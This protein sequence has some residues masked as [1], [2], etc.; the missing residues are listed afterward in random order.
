MMQTKLDDMK[1]VIRQFREIS[2]ELLAENQSLSEQLKIS[3][4]ACQNIRTELEKCQKDHKIEIDDLK[5]RISELKEE[6]EFLHSDKDESSKK[7]K[8]LRAE[9]RALIT[10]N[11]NLKR[12]IGSDNN[13]EKM[14]KQIL[15][16]DKFNETKIV[17]SVSY[18][19]I[20][21]LNNINFNIKNPFE[22][23]DSGSSGEETRLLNNSSEDEC[24]DDVCETEYC[25]Y[26]YNNAE[27]SDHNHNSEESE[28]CDWDEKNDNKQ[29]IERNE[30]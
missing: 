4:E 7:K 5:Q 18:N 14:L 26:Q 20:N 11:E 13:I 24:K 19:I 1:T 2:Q 3:R 23:E 28:K 8:A 16:M 6:N 15:E 17:D 21:Y 9:N 29:E 30:S 10:E 22:S 12:Q 25:G 27:C